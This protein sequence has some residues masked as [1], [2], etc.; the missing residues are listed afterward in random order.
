METLYA[1]LRDVSSFDLTGALN[2]TKDL[3]KGDVFLKVCKN[4]NKFVQRKLSL[5]EDEERIE[6]VNDP[7]KGFDEEPRFILLKD[8]IDLTLGLGSVVMKKNK[9]GGVIL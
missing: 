9:V 3:M 1:R 5:S 7:P 2:L 6:W 8:I 4:T